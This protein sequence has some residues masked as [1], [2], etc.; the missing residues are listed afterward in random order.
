M[1]TSLTDRYLE[2]L[3]QEMEAAGH[4][5]EILLAD[6]TKSEDMDRTVQHALELWGHIDVFINNVGDAISKPMVP[7][8]GSQGT[9]PVSDDE[10]RFVVGRKPDPRVFGVPCRGPAHAEPSQGQGD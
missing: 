10:W 9:T 7:L 5:I 6:A 3:R 4:P 2:P 1:A 8:P